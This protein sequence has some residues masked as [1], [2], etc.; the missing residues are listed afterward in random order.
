MGSDWI[1]IGLQ[2]PIQNLKA[3]KE[4]SQFAQKTPMTNSPEHQPTGRLEIIV[5]VEGLEQL[6]P[7]LESI[8]TNLN[9]SAPQL[10][11]NDPSDV[12]IYC[13]NLFEQEV[14]NVLTR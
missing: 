14:F 9:P 5:K 7:I 13:D 10:M 3:L 2:F 1:Q 8:A 4:N 11:T 6:L 12:Q